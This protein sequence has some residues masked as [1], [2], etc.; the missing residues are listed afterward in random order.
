[1]LYGLDVTFGF[2]HLASAESTTI[3]ITA[4]MIAFSPVTSFLK[5]P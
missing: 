3:Q 2:L 4:A 1:M 5:K